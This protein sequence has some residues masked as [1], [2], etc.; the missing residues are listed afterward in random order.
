MTNELKLAIEWAMEQSDELTDHL[1]V[2]LV[3]E[4]FNNN[5]IE[6]ET[7]CYED[8]IPYLEEAKQ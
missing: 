5:E 2:D 3:R 8:L 1:L 4:Y 6:Y 7:F